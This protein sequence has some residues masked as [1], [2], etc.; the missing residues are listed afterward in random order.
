M[1]A[2]KGREKIIAA[3]VGIIPAVWLALLTAPFLDGG[4]AEIVSGLP[5]ALCR[6]FAITICKDSMKTVFIFLCSYMI[7]IGIAFSSGRN[8]RR[9]EEMGSAVWGDAA[10]LDRKYRAAADSENKILT[11]NVW[12][13]LDGRKH[14]RNLNVLVCGG[15]GSGK[16]R[17][18]CKPNLMQ[19]N[20]SLVVLD[21]KGGAIRSCM[22]SARAQLNN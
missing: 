13:G 12:I 4:L 9:G 15:S 7:G 6:P 19:A 8:Y 2:V 10:K 21:P 16:T 5:D 17:F 18:Y 1:T 11:Q 14:R 3:V 22:K 20:T